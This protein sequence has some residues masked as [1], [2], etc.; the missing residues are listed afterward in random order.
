MPLFER[1]RG[2]AHRRRDAERLRGEALAR[3]VEPGYGVE[4]K[5]ARPHGR[6]GKRRLAV[7]P[8]AIGLSQDRCIAVVAP[9]PQRDLRLAGRGVFPSDC[10][11]RRRQLLAADLR[12][13]A[14]LQADRWLPLRRPE[15]RPCQPLLPEVVLDFPAGPVGDLRAGW[16]LDDSPRAIL[17]SLEA[18]GSLDCRGQRIKRPRVGEELRLR[19]RQHVC[20]DEHD[21][22]A[23]LHL[24]EKR[25]TGGPQRIGW[26]R[27]GMDVL[28]EEDVVG[29][30]QEAHDASL[31]RVATEPVV[32]VICIAPRGIEVQLDALRE[33]GD[34]PGVGVHALAWRADE[35]VG[36]HRS[37]CERPG[38]GRVGRRAAVEPVGLF[39][40][41]LGRIPGRRGACQR[42]GHDE[43][44]RSPDDRP[45][46]GAPAHLLQREASLCHG[47]T[48]P[49]ESKVTQTVRLWR[50][51]RPSLLKMACAAAH[52]RRNIRRRCIHQRITHITPSV[53]APS[54]SGFMPGPA[55]SNTPVPRCVSRAL[56]M[57]PCQRC[58]IR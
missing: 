1:D 39:D 29:L 56:S 6:Q 43:N 50:G 51:G 58:T 44:G 33:F 53:A 46:T 21:S 45:E 47:V 5:P 40:L 41:P 38:P 32:L 7:G 27:L 23:V 22:R 14:D 57:K 13:A 26:Q 49:E 19:L 30:L 34:L 9:Q 24:L 55:I 17:E 4:V 35:R 52:T 16:H 36:P 2:D 42:C 3:G 37:T 25:P 48:R 18:A 15:H 31:A 20:A 11:L 54:R 28:E 8:L 10:D 12:I